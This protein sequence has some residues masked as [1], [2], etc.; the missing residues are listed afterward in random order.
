[1][2]DEPKPDE[3]LTA[4]AKLMR[5]TVMPELSGHTAFLVR[6]AANAVDLVRRQIELQPGL[7]RAE[8]GRLTALLGRTG[9]LAELNLALCEAIE[10]RSVSLE[11]PGLADHLW[12]TTMA[13]L[14]VDQPGYAAYQHARSVEDKLA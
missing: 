3:I 1:M 4:V 11:T 8:L 14:A 9:S 6:V 10:K 2:Q 13:K 5:E 7:D 12:A